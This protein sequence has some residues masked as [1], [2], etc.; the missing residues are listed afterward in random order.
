MNCCINDA[1]K[2]GNLLPFT[3]FSNILS[4]P[5]VPLYHIFMYFAFFIFIFHLIETVVSIFLTLHFRQIHLNIQFG[6][7]RYRSQW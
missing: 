1:F 6:G 5:Y 3:L 2:Q 4:Q 7:I